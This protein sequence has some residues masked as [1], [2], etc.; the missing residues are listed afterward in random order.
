MSKAFMCTKKTKAMKKILTNRNNI[1][2][3]CI[4][5]EMNI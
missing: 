4:D 3:G 1:N 2:E 5:G